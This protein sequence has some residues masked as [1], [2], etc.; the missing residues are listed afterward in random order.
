MAAPVVASAVELN[1]EMYPAVVDWPGNNE[2]FGML[3]VK[4]VDALLRGLK[5]HHEYGAP[6]TPKPGAISTKV[7]ALD[8]TFVN[9]RSK[10]WKVT[11]EPATMADHEPPSERRDCVILTKHWP[12]AGDDDG[13]CEQTGM[14]DGGEERGSAAEGRST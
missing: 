10:I 6:T 12:C 1:C 5:F 13:H 4:N 3:T 7:N 9:V 11:L 8:P 2:L 14:R